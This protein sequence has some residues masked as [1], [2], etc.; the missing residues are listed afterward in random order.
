MLLKILMSETSRSCTRYPQS[1]QLSLPYRTVGLP[2]PIQIASNLLSRFV[3]MHNLSFAHAYLHT[4]LLACS[5]EAVNTALQIAMA[6]HQEQVIRIGQHFHNYL[7]H[8][9]ISLQIGQLDDFVHEYYEQKRGETTTLSH[10]LIR[11][12][13]LAYFAIYSN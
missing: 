7:T 1:S 8:F 10:T 12:K 3:D 4:E 11:F 6:R 2:L 9:K 5:I 13:R